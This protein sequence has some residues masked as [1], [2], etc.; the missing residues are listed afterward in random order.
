MRR[1]VQKEE[2]L[3]MKNYKILISDSTV[4]TSTTT[5][6]FRFKQ[7]IRILELAKI[8]KK[9]EKLEK[10]RKIAKNPEK[11]RI[12]QNCIAFLGK[13]FKIGQSM[14]QYFPSD[15]GKYDAK[16][17]SEREIKSLYEKKLFWGEI[18]PISVKKRSFRAIFGLKL[19]EFWTEIDFFDANFDPTRSF[20]GPKLTK[21]R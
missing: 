20:F 6:T 13:N 17:G 18:W 12:F 2:I 1:S 9:T 19:T 8:V 11:N 15:L 16:T 3:R 10:V 5:F 4:L 7:K 14:C 21:F